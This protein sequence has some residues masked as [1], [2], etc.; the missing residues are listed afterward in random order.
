VLRGQAGTA[1]DLIDEASACGIDEPEDRQLMYGEPQGQAGQLGYV[2]GSGQRSA[3][4]PRP[5]P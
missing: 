5:A 2:S 3:R 4:Q 1:I